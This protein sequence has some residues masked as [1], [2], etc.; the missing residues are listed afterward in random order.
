MLPRRTGS[1]TGGDRNMDH[2]STATARSPPCSSNDMTSDADRRWLYRCKFSVSD[3]I[4]SPMAP[5]YYCRFRPT[6]QCLS[7]MPL[8]LPAS[9]AT[10]VLGRCSQK[11]KK[12]RTQNWIRPLIIFLI[13]QCECSPI[14]LVRACIIIVINCSQT[15]DESASKQQTAW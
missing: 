6:G 14:L 4:W 5:L 13:Q 2:I 11:T 9:P 3:R 12:G 8:N 15:T 10:G 7:A 1:S